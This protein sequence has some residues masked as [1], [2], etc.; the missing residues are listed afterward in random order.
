VETPKQE[1][2]A[3]HPAR[4]CLCIATRNHEHTT[5]H[6]WARHKWA[7]HKWAR[8]KWAR[9]SRAQLNRPAV[10]STQILRKTVQRLTGGEGGPGIQRIL[11]FVN[12]TE[13]YKLVN[14]AF[15][16]LDLDRLYIDTGDNTAQRLDFRLHERGVKES[17]G[18]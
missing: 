1:E 16:K 6:K 2:Q 9:H 12:R 11:D 15:R 5:R 8:H 7:R 4:H 17:K 10:A 3:H 13:V 14:T 18:F